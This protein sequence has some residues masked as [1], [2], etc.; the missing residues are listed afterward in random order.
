MKMELVDINIVK[1]NMQNPRRISEEKLDYL[2][3]SINDFGE[4]MQLRPIIVDEDYTI[5]GGNMRYRAARANCL[6]QIWIKK[7]DD[8][9]E[10]EKKEL[11]I[12]DNINVGIWDSEKLTNH[13]EKEKLDEIGL[14]FIP[15]PLDDDYLDQFYVDKEEGDK[16]RGNELTPFTIILQY[17]KEEVDDVKDKLLQH[18]ETM[19]EGLKTLLGI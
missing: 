10:S 4:M 13:W 17:P 7:I 2:K 3:K 8:L 5:L 16:S 18:G 1:P 9:T 14:Y 12:K 11:I 19:E 6:K 15:E